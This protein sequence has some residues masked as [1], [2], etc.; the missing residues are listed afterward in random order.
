MVWLVQNCRSNKCLQFLKSPELQG[1]VPLGPLPGFYPGPAG[2]LKRSPDPSPTHVLIWCYSKD[3]LYNRCT[4]EI[5]IINAD[6]VYK[7]K[8]PAELIPSGMLISEDM[9]MYEDIKETTKI[10]LRLWYLTP[11]ST[12]FQLYRGGQFYNFMTC[13]IEYTSQ[14]V[15]FELTTLL[16]I[17][18]DCIG[19]CKSNYHTIATTTTPTKNMEGYICAYVYNHADI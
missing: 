3:W 10:V 9:L 6:Q 17:A 13:C 8:I 18:T 15:G 16:V 4:R 5:K 19:S 7:R 11:L 12:I 14:W 2:D 1:E